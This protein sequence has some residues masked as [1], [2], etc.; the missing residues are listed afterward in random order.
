MLA[1]GLAQAARSLGE[2]GME[3]LV[4]IG[5]GLSLMGLAGVIWSMVKVARAKGRNLPDAELREV[6]RAMLPWNIGALFVSVLGLVM[7]TVGLA[8]A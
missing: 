3:I 8:L 4:W 5:A 2:H 7:V 1:D 6:M